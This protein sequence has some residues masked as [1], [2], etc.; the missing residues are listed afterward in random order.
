MGTSR[1]VESGRS[2]IFS[3]IPIKARST[4]DL[5]KF[6]R[7]TMGTNRRVESGRSPIFSLIP[8]KARSTKDLRKFVRDTM[9]VHFPEINL[10]L[11]FHLILI[12]ARC[13]AALQ[14]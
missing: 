6:V 12:K 7:D 14:R 3:L 4:K 13:T 9:A 2:P 11:S 5:R 1:R 8:I 10:S